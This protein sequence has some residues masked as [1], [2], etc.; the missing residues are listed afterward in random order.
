MDKAG[1]R[2]FPA[3]HVPKVAVEWRRDRAGEIRGGN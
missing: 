1:S 3:I 2:I